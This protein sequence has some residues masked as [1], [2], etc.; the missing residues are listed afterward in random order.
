MYLFDKSDVVVLLLKIMLKLLPNNLELWILYKIACEK[1]NDINGAEFCLVKID[2]LMN[3]TIKDNFCEFQ[4]IRK[5]LSW[6]ELKTS[7]PVYFIINRQ[8]KMGLLKYSSLFREYLL[9]TQPHLE[10]N[11]DLNYLQVIE[12]MIQEDHENGLKKLHCFVMND[13]TEMM[14]RYVKGNL[15]YSA[16][17]I[18]KA[19]CEY[20][21]AYN[22]NLKS[23]ED[24]FL[25]IP[26][27][28]CGNAYLYNFPCNSKAKK[29]Y[30]RCCKYFPTFNSW[31]GLGRTYRKVRLFQF[32]SFINISIYIFLTGN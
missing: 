12:L 13:D 20:E 17:D 8:L 18:S 10:D 5:P 26:T 4:N 25:H 23:S 7:N 1:L 27:M 3:E 31:I 15:L 9:N 11:F 24:N 29:Y 2:E 19:I 14:L 30:H 32:N 28:R 21:I 16:G 22:I 6:I